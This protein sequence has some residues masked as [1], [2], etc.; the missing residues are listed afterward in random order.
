MLFVTMV[1]ST[2]MQHV[3]T[4][5]ARPRVVHHTVTVATL[6]TIANAVCCAHTL[7]SQQDADTSSAAAAQPPDAC[8]V[9]DIYAITETV[10]SHVHTAAA[11]A[12]ALCRSTTAQQSDS[13]SHDTTSNNTINGDVVDHVAAVVS[14]TLLSISAD[15]LHTLPDL[16]PAASSSSSSSGSVVS[17]SSLA[18]AAAVAAHET[19]AVRAVCESVAQ[20]WSS[21]CS[22]MQAAAVER[23]TAAVASGEATAEAADALHSVITALRA[24]HTRYVVRPDQIA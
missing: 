20:R 18:A 4:C 23:E 10:L 9:A 17:A 24:Q 15:I 5:I 7:S 3:R 16:A 21:Y 11:A 22:A 19:A 1:L 6:C 12:G 14:H 2:L 13:Q 8:T